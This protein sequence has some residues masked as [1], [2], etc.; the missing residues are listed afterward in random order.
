M[1]LGIATVD[2]EVFTWII[3]Y[4]RN[5]KI[6]AT[7]QRC[8]LIIHNRNISHTF[9]V[10]HRSNC[11]KAEISQSTVSWFHSGE[12]LKYF[13]GSHKCT[14]ELT[15]AS[16]FEAISL[17]NVLLPL[18]GGPNT[19]ILQGICGFGE[20]RYILGFVMNWTRASFVDMLY[21]L[22]KNLHEKVQYTNMHVIE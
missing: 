16:Y 13:M 18:I 19:Q 21:I 17:A 11:L 14:N 6:F 1:L 20:F 15:M 8:A 2:Q 10:C 3:F 9:S 7:R 22:S 4:V 5:F 12:T